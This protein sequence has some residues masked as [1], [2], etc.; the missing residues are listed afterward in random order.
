MYVYQPVIW[1]ARCPD[2]VLQHIFRYFEKKW[3]FRII[4][5]KSFLFWRVKKSRPGNSEIAILK[6]SLLAV[7]CGFLLP[8]C[9]KSIFLVILQTFVNFQKRCL[10]IGSLKP[11]PVLWGYFGPFLWGFCSITRVI[12]STTMTDCFMCYKHNVLK[13]RLRRGI[14]SYFISY[15]FWGIF[16]AQVPRCSWLL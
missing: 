9:F 15:I 3:K 8:F 11:R 7:F 2:M 14:F 16:S 12:D 5:Q 13:L 10:D 6:N 1:H 4:T